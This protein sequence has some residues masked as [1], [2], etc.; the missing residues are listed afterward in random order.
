MVV[1]APEYYKSFKCIA[2]KCKHSCCL[3]WEV[4]IDDYTLDIY[5][6]TKGDFGEILNNNISYVNDTACFKL[7][8]NKRCPFLMPDGLCQLIIKKGEDFLCD[9]CTEHPRFYNFL[10]DRQEVGLGLCCEEATRL[11][12]SGDYDYKLL[13]LYENDDLLNESFS[14]EKYIIGFRE[15]I[16]EILDKNKKDFKKCL[17][18]ISDIISKKNPDL[19]K[20]EITVLYMSLEMLD[21]SWRSLLKEYDL[22]D[23]DFNVI[24]D[25][26]SEYYTRLLFYFVFRHLTSAIYDGRIFERLV[27]GILS[28]KY[29]MNL[30]VFLSNGNIKEGI[31]QDIARRY[32]SE[33]EYSDENIEKILDYIT[34]KSTD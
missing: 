24:Y 26:Y 28:T 27:F 6:N 9:I 1:F 13:P 21:N 10:S 15:R 30:S 18:E 32:S 17:L 12:I 33:I 8:S 5:L 4:E 7:D 31:L 14:E 3:G 29:I 23:Y 22:C 34:K 16:F 11:V 2:D 19:N 25:N 20:N